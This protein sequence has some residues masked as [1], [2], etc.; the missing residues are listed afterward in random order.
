MTQTFDLFGDLVPEGWGKRGRPQHIAT[1]ENRNK[2]NMLLAFGWNNERIA[3]ALGITAPTL[4][5]NYFRELKF[6]E[7]ARDRLDSSLA[8][9]CWEQVQAGNVG[10]MREFARLLERNDLMTYGQRSR[11]QAAPTKKEPKLGK[12]EAAELAAQQPDRS[13]TLG[14]LMA[15]RQVDDGLPN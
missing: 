6:R 13:T 8:M 2:V 10:A 7:E 11:P 4:R 3:R 14:D 1:L 12:K 5:K 15:Q 9:K